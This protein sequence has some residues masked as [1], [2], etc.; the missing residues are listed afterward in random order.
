MHEPKLSL[1]HHVESTEHGQGSPVTLTAQRKVWGFFRTCA[2]LICERD[3]NGSINTD[4]SFDLKCKIVFP[5]QNNFS[6]LVI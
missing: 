6:V 5:L 3:M 2:L 1:L 4:N